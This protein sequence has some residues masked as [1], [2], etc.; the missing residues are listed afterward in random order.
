MSHKNHDGIDFAPRVAIEGD[1]P[2][3]TKD[4]L[5]DIGLN[6]WTYKTIYNRDRFPEV[7][8]ATTQAHENPSSFHLLCRDNYV[9]ICTED[10]LHACERAI[11]R[12][13]SHPSYRFGP[14]C[15]EKDDSTESEGEES[16]EEGDGDFV[17]DEDDSTESEGEESNDESPVWEEEDDSTET[18][19]KTAKIGDA[20]VS[21]DYVQFMPH[22][23]QVWE[24][25]GF[26]DFGGRGGRDI[27]AI[28]RPCDKKVTA[29]ATIIGYYHTAVVSEM[30][31]YPTLR[32]VRLAD[33]P[34]KMD[35]IHVIAYRHIREPWLLCVWKDNSDDS[36]GFDARDFKLVE[37]KIVRLKY[38]PNE[39]DIWLGTVRRIA[40]R[41]LMSQESRV[42]GG[43]K[44]L[45][46]ALRRLE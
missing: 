41:A 7:V 28:R 40:S 3:W 2:S 12:G 44:E 21:Y 13:E 15:Y 38:N 42:K 4:K 45:E 18:R 20:D 10:W 17:D 14:W 27:L 11:A 32:P 24:A 37:S 8:V 35:D 31:S 5:N 16:N 1:L 29:A 25:I 43:T 19:F 22:G 23:Y 26:A 46:A 33:L 39:V 30:K 6:L 36:E 34:D 9:P